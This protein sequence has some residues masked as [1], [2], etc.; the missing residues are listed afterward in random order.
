MFTVGRPCAVLFDRDGTLIKDIPHN[1]DPAQVEPL[2]GAAEALRRLRQAGVA[3]GVVTSQSGV[4][5]G[6][7]SADAM[8]QVNTRVEELLG[9]FDAWA[10]C[11][12]EDADGCACR[13]PAP[14]LV[15]RI[16]CA[17]NVRPVECL[18]VGDIGSDMQ[19]AESAGADGILVPS[20]Q[21]RP[22]EIDRAPA[23]AQDL[24]EVT[25]RVLEA[26]PR[27]DAMERAWARLVGWERW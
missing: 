21:T 8:D 7:I 18:V 26:E 6:L 14:G 17:L 4:A 19:A 27:Q 5:R 24:A 2:P 20:Q 23:V 13:T 10:I 22:A 15:I 9:P 3:V 25:D 12:H 16:A 11:I 1:G